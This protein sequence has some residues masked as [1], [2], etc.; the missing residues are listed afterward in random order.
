MNI[1]LC[2]YLDAVWTSEQREITGMESAE[3]TFTVVMD[4][5]GARYRFKP[6]LNIWACTQGCVCVYLKQNQQGIYIG[7]GGHS[8]KN[9][10]FHHQLPHDVDTFLSVFCKLKMK[11]EEERR[12]NKK[13]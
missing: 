8:S 4:P 7:I 5:F 10:I 9:C 12:K 6:S 2:P 3:E 13:V 11:N 1:L